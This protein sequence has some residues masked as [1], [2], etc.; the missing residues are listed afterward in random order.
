M[1]NAMVKVASKSPLI[2]SIVAVGCLVGTAVSAVR[3]YKK[4]KKILDRKLEL[5]ELEEK[6]KPEEEKTA[7][8]SENK[9][10]RLLEQ[11]KAC[12]TAWIPTAAIALG[13]IASIILAHKI[14]AGQLAAV[15]AAGAFGYKKFNDQKYKIRKFIGEKNYRKLEN[16][17]AGDAVEKSGLTANGDVIP[18]HDQF[19]GIVITAKPEDVKQVFLDTEKEMNTNGV[20]VFS[21]YIRRLTDISTTEVRTPMGFGSI[22]WSADAFIEKSERIWIDF[23]LERHEEDGKVYAEIRYPYD[24]TSDFINVSQQVDDSQFIEENPAFL[25]E[26]NTSSKI[27]E[28]AV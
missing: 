11:G 13:G 9:F 15:S 20:V 5:H 21:D 7:L 2:F 4:A 1:S 26:A 8:W 14:S 24:P 17:I 19:S 22:G 27:V 18:V 3:D 23:Q 6:D 10:E 28:P 16:L 12:W 25:I